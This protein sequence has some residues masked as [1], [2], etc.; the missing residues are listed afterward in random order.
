M[1]DFY[2]WNPAVGSSSC[3]FLIPFKFCFERSNIKGVPTSELQ[4]MSGIPISELQSMSG[5]PKLEM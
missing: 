5:V 1:E 4:T 2:A 3:L